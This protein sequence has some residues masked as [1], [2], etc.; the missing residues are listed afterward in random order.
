MKRSIIKMKRR[1]IKVKID[2]IALNELD[3]TI[4]LTLSMVFFKIVIFILEYNIDLSRLNVTAFDNNNNNIE[5][6]LLINLIFVY[7]QF[8]THFYLIQKQILKSI[9]QKIL[10]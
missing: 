10:T 5:Q 4:L 8:L 3:I 2:I 7:Y 1:I 6:G 9:I